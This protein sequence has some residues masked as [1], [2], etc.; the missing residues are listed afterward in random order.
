MSD[1]YDDL[2]GLDRPT[3]PDLPAMPISD[4]AAQFSPFAAV[5]GYADAVEETSRY[6]DVR[7]DLQED[8]AYELN[9][10]ARTGKKR[11]W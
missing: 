2:I 6:T 7:I 8:A 10:K 1:K 3:Y 5:A 4:R 11:Y 9:Q